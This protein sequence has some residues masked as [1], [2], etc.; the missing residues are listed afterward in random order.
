[1]KSKVPPPQQHAPVPGQRTEFAE[2]LGGLMRRLERE[3]ML[4]IEMI[5]SGIGAFKNCDVSA[6]AA[7]R[8]RDD[9]VDREEVRIEE[10]ALRLIALHQPVAS[11][12]RRLTLIIKANADLERV[13]DHATGLCKSVLQLEEPGPIHWPPALLEMADRLLPRAHEAVRA[14][15]RLDAKLAEQIISDDE[16]MDTLW[17]RAFEEIEQGA[18]VGRLSVRASLLAFRAGRE[19][20]R[21]SDLLA[22]I[23]ED[24]IYMQTGRIVRHAKR[25]AQ[26]KAQQQG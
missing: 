21:I 11:D 3:A 12:L 8:R 5:E 7:V 23:C 4:I 24:I 26:Q 19:L 20:E 18:Q 16:T 25:I 2:E 13:A 6:A 1:M 10:E 14:L 17:R 15:Q 22:N 9:E